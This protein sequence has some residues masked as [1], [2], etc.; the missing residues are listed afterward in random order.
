[1]KMNYLKSY[2]SLSFIAILIIISSCSKDIDLPNSDA[3]KLIGSWKWVESSG[4]FSGRII[5]PSTEGYTKNL[6]FLKNGIYTESRNKK[7]YTD[8]QYT[9]HKA[10]SIYSTESVY[11]IK[12]LKT[13]NNSYDNE[14]QSF[15]FSGND[16][17]Y[18][19]DECH[20]CYSHIYVRE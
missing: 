10:H 15:Q 7:W 5:S 16:T 6:E 3:E 17:L 14:S 4:G 8:L 12:Y 13:P 9:F 19:K 18:L 20:D 11:Q 2:F 1:M